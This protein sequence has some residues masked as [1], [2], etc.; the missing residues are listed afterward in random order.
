[1]ITD[2]CLVG[3]N[4]FRHHKHCNHFTFRVENNIIKAKSKLLILN[5]K[6]KVIKNITFDKEYCFISLSDG[7]YELIDDEGKIKRVA[8]FYFY[9]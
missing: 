2:E 1:M 5:S 9:N 8:K 7:F 4:I 3:C 6:R